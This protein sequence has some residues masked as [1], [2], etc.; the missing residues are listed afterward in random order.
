MIIAYLVMKQK[1][2]LNKNANLLVKLE[3]FT[4]Y[5]LPT[6]YSK[7]FSLVYLIYLTIYQLKC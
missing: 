1:V 5:T 3:Y 4:F 2:V 7:L 6:Y